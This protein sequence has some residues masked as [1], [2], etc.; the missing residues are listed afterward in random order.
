LLNPAHGHAMQ[1]RVMGEGFLGK[2]FFFR[3]SFIRHLPARSA[4]LDSIQL[5]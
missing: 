4:A 1:A 5:D 2:S 3:N